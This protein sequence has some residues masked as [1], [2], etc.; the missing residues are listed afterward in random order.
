[1]KLNSGFDLNVI[2]GE[3]CLISGGTAVGG[4][5]NIGNNVIIAGQVGIIDHLNI[6]DNSIIA[7]KSGVFKSFDNNSFISGTPARH[8]SDRLR[9]D[10]LITK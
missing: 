3:N 1:M 5:T 4:S 9:Q 7:A 2:I 10:V 8:H 6:G